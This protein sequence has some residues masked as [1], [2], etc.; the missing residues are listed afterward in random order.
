[1]VQVNSNDLAK[2][3]YKKHSAVSIE[4]NYGVFYVGCISQGGK[5]VYLIN[6][7][8]YKILWVKVFISKEETV[9]PVVTCK[10]YW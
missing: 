10:D 4:F 6:E 2:E 8:I 9:K 5:H 7:N 1:M 3:L